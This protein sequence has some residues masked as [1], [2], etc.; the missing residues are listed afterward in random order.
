MFSLLER[1]VFR[2]VYEG[3]LSGKKC[4]WFCVRKWNE[5]REDWEAKLGEMGLGIEREKRKE[6]QCG[7]SLK[8][9]NAIEGLTYICAPHPTRV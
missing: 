7:V 5:N 4:G 2:L 3:V 6:R 8:V 1:Q 9:M